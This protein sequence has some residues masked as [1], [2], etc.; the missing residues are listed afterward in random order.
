MIVWDL[1]TDRNCLHSRNMVFL[2]GLL[3][4]YGISSLLNVRYGLLENIKGFLWMVLQYGLLFSYN[5][6]A[7]KKLYQR[8]AKGLMIAFCFLTFA[9][10]CG[11]HHVLARVW[12]SF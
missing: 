8:Q 4:V 12:E 5:A 2:A 10:P 6:S 9:H 11:N 7:E 1:L 3:A